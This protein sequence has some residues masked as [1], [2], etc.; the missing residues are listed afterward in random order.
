MQPL[1]LSQ[2]VMDE[3]SSRILM[4]TFDRSASALELSRQFGIPIAACYRRIKELEVLG[5]VFCERE[6]PSR[7]GKGLQLFRSRL[8]SVRISLEDGNLRARVEVG[9]PGVLAAPQGE[10]MEQTM[11]L[12]GALAPA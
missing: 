5:L 11:N 7:N 9:P 12:R 6:L 3:Y 10:V 4:G 8:K 1:E 2:T